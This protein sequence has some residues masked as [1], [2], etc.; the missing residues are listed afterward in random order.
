MPKIFQFHLVLFGNPLESQK[1]N[2]QGIFPYKAKRRIRL[3]VSQKKK[4]LDCIKKLGYSNKTRLLNKLKKKIIY[5]EKHFELE[6]FPNRQ[7]TR[8]WN[9]NADIP[10]RYYIQEKHPN[11][12]HCFATVSFFGKSKLRW[13]VNERIGRRGKFNY[14]CFFCIYVL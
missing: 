14:I 11:K 4:R 13:Y 2:P 8:F 1:R 3:T 7:N 10:G 6:S 12:I 5:D 9:Q